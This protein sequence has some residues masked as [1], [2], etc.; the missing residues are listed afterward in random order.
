MCTGPIPKQLAVTIEDLGEP[1][2][3]THLCSDQ[4][5]SSEAQD[6]LVIP[7]ENLGSLDEFE[8]IYLQLDAP[9]YPLLLEEE[10]RRFYEK[11]GWD[12]VL[13]LFYTSSSTTTPT[14]GSLLLLIRKTTE[15]SSLTPYYHPPKR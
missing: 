8:A 2:T 3:D 4:H 12:P 15:I 13:W 1:S 14:A 6:R 10:S 11:H 7:P 9:Q 5:A